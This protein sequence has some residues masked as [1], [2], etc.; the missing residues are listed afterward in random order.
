MRFLILCLAIVACD[1]SD[2]ILVSSHLGDDVHVEDNSLY[3]CLNTRVDKLG[4]PQF[5]FITK[6]RV[7]IRR[8][9]LG[10]DGKECRKP[11]QLC[12]ANQDTECDDEIFCTKDTCVNGR[13]QYTPDDSL[14]G[15]G[16]TCAVEYGACTRYCYEDGDCDLGYGHECLDSGPADYL[17]E[18][19][20]LKCD[21]NTHLCL[22]TFSLRQCSTGMSCVMSSD[23][24]V[25]S[26]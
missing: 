15:P 26:D 21:V 5:H 7:P 14:C 9:T 8:C 19:A 13:C 23:R 11:P 4:Q 25:Q 1:D 10:C 22:V 3:G 17:S 20:Q 12:P 18:G 24:C 16:D 6:D 2:R